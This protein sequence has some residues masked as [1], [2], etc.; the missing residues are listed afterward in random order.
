M[1]DKAW[2]LVHTKPQ[3]EETAMANLHR[4]GYEAFLPRARR[5]IRHNGRWRQKVDALF[6]RYL[7]LYLDAD[8]QDWRPIH[9]TV[10]ISR[11]VRFGTWPA[12]VPES[13][14]EE[15][16]LRADTD[17]I[18]TT[19]QP[20]ELEPGQKIRVT[21]GPLTGVEGIVAA[22]NGRDRVD[23][24]LAIVGQ[25]ARAQLPTSQVAGVRE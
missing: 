12:R 18:V 17:G 8:E 10:G 22:K 5:S 23:L 1:P 21:E 6:P 2:H 3:R 14:V 11:L 19:E 15:F 9:S 25:S 24:L 20:E 4:Q 16:R 13:L 7:F